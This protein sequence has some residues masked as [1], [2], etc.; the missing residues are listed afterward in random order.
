MRASACWSRAPFPLALEWLLM[1]DPH[2]LHLAASQN[3]KIWAI[4]YP[5]SF[6]CDLVCLLLT[7]KCDLVAFSLLSL[8]LV[9]LLL[10]RWKVICFKLFDHLHFQQHI[11]TVHQ[12]WWNKQNY[13][14]RMSWFAWARNNRCD[15]ISLTVVAHSFY[16]S[17][18][19]H[20]C[21]HWKYFCTVDKDRQKCAFY[22]SM[23]CQKWSV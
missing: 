17:L 13:S 5:S 7:L 18:P 4:K 8:T 2:I 20:I 23:S 12:K 14:E 9:L 10:D 3:F 22:T 6:S 21:C 19:S 11:C 1:Y 15:Y 16:K